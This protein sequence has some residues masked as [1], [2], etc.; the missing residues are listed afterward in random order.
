M[1]ITRVIS[2]D[3]YMG[4]S[5]KISELNDKNVRLESEL[6]QLKNMKEEVLIIEVDNKGGNK[7]YKKKEKDVITML[8]QE[9]KE[10]RDKLVYYDEVIEKNEHLSDV[11]LN[12]NSIITNYKYDIEVLNEENNNLL[13]ELNTLKNRTLSQK[14]KDLFKK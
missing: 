9:N 5:S 13:E 6:K 2:N 8:V 4:L 7:E 11:I 12:N 3:E 1:D 10:Y 14:L